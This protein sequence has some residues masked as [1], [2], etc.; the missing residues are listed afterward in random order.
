M[1]WYVYAFQRV[2]SEKSIEAGQYV[3]DNCT[4]DE[5][6]NWVN[7]SIIYS[8]KHSGQ[9]EK[10]TECAIKHDKLPTTVNCKSILF[11]QHPYDR[12]YEAVMNVCEE[13]KHDFETENEF[14]GSI[15]DMEAYRKIIN[16]LEK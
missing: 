10:A 1:A 8:Y 2:N 12:Q 15:R 14:Y 16:L 13:L 5:I 7:S 4:D 6:R 9:V 11:N 3:L